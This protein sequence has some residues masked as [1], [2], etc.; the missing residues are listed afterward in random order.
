[1]R[2]EVPVRSMPHSSSQAATTS[3]DCIASASAFMA[4][5][6]FWFSV[7]KNIRVLLLA[8]RRPVDRS[9]SAGI[10]IS[11]VDRA[12]ATS[13]SSMPRGRQCVKGCSTGWHSPMLRR[14]EPAV[15][16]VFINDTPE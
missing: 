10:S 2:S 11:M 16:A 15:W 6:F 13:P 9:R 5:Y 1:M 4:G 14:R 12:K 8:S 7:S 3:G